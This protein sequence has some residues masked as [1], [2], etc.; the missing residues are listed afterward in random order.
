MLLNTLVSFFV[1][2]KAGGQRFFMYSR[3]ITRH[4]L[5]PPSGP[6]VTGEGLCHVEF[7][8]APEDAQSWFVGSA[9]VKN[10]FHQMRFLG[11]LQAFLYSPLFSHPKLVEP[12]RTVNEK[13]LA[14]DSLILIYPVP[15]TLRMVFCWAMFFCQYVTD[16]CTPSGSAD[17]SLFVCRDHSTPPLAR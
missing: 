11:W 16:H 10:A 13:R 17:S 14:P 4:L 1:A 15:T 7:Q 5:K 9:D 3:A 8:G 12:G 6:L 2:R